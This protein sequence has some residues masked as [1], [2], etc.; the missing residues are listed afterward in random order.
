M[1]IPF[2]RALDRMVYADVLEHE[3][4]RG[5]R[6]GK[7]QAD[8]N[9]PKD[10]N[11]DRFILS[12]GHASAALY[13]TLAQAGFVGEG[14]LETFCQPDGKLGGHPDIDSIPGVEA[15]TGALGH[16][17]PF[18]VGIALSGKIDKKDYRVYTVLGDGECQEGSVWEAAQFAAHHKLDNL[19]AI[20]DYNKLQAMG[21]ISDILGL[22]PVARKWD[23]FNWVVREVNGHDIDKL[24]EVLSSVPFEKEKP[25]LVIAHTI[26]GKGISFMENVPLW[27]Y[28][29]P[30]EKE[31][32]I[33][34]KELG[35]ETLTK[36]F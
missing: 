35:L 36:G 18:S 27:H 26:K 23:S 34:L 6:S 31:T 10:N 17:F 7:V 32:E 4:R 11:R 9:N 25:N 5:D 20:L 22:E 1:V 30:N 15:T 24:M 13:A 8:K 21:K 19:T 33:S 14:V 28:R 2:H 16:G 12:K 3:G 29:L